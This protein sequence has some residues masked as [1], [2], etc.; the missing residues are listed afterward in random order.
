MSCRLPAMMAV[1]AA[2]DLAYDAHQRRAVLPIVLHHAE[3]GQSDT[4]L[5]LTGGE[6]Q[7]VYAQLDRA[8]DQRARYQHV[9]GRVGREH[10]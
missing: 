4:V 1:P 2:R 6:M 3:G 5:V 8:V 10:S 9:P 7:R